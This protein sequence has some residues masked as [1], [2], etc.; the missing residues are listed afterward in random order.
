MEGQ[1]AGTTVVIPE[2]PGTLFLPP[3][4]G[5]LVFT[6]ARFIPEDPFAN[7]LALPILPGS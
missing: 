3:D 2:S 1:P 6:F 4:K 7:F 5:A